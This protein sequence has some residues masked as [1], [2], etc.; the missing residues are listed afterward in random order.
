MSGLKLQEKTRFPSSIWMKRNRKAIHRFIVDTSGY[1]SF[2][3]VS[4]YIINVLIVK[5]TLEQYL[6][7]SI[8][9]TANTIILARPYGWFLDWWRKKLGPKSVFLSD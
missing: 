4:S 6:A 7:I 5:I 9:G 8:I 2:W 1:F 3:S